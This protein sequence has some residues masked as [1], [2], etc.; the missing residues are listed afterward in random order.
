MVVNLYL[1]AAQPSNQMKSATDHTLADG[2]LWPK[3]DLARFL[4]ERV[5]TAGLETVTSVSELPVNVLA[6]SEVI[7]ELL[8]CLAPRLRLV[9]GSAMAH[10]RE[11]C[12]AS[13]GNGIP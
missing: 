4:T 2:Y 10:I 6:G 12:I 7:K 8:D 9:T 11:Q 13:I 1:G 3:V 5:K